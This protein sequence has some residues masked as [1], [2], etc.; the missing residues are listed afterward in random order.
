MNAGRPTGSAIKEIFSGLN[1]LRK[2]E[3]WLYLWTVRFIQFIAIFCVIEV[4]GVWIFHTFNI[5]TSIE[6]AR[7][8]LSAMVQAQAAIV[9]LVITLTLIAIQMA[10]A[11]Y[12]P[13]VVDV[14]K[15]SPDMWFLLVIYIEAMSIGFFVLEIVA[16]PVN[17]Y[18]VSSVMIL[19]IFTFCILFLYMMNTIALLRPDAVVKML[20]EEINAENIYQEGWKKESE[21][22]IMQPV[23]DMVHASINRFDVTTTRT[24]L[25][26]LSERILGLFPVYD[27]NS[28]EKI[29]VDIARHFCEHIRRSALVALRNDDEGM[30]NE[31]STVLQKFGIGFCDYQSPLVT[32]VSPLTTPVSDTL[33]FIG[34]HTADK[35]LDLATLT[36]VEALKEVGIHSADKGLDFATLRV[37]DA[38]G[39]VGIH[40]ADKEL[41]F[42]TFCVANALGVMGINAADKVKELEGATWMV[43]N[44]LCHLGLKEFGQYSAAESLAQLILCYKS[45]ITELIHGFESTL[46]PEEKDQFTT[47][48]NEVNKALHNL[49]NLQNHSSILL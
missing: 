12:T 49:E 5:L 15:K 40:S 32:P 28:R 41:V 45:T 46:N 14:M 16:D 27:E 34:I 7:Y 39:E 38:L 44:K 26:A 3:P 18:L 13:R 43:V 33:A 24:G 11:S 19:G 48:M 35:G 31:I 9:A 8:F 6:N 4:A 21:D 20:V 42:A 1:E 36:V 25:N 37:A 23:F 2:K 10:S 22:D 29:A 17:Q 47:F 30:L